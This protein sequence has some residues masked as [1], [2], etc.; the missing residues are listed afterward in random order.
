MPRELVHWLVLEEFCERIPE[1][2]QLLKAN[3]NVMYLGSLVPDAPYYLN[4]GSCP[5]S[6]KLGDHLHGSLGED[7]FIPIKRLLHYREQLSDQKHCEL[8][9]ALSLAILTHIV[10]DAVFHPMLSYLTGNWYAS[11]AS[12]RSAA[13]R[14][15][16][17]LEVY[18]DSWFVVKRTLGNKN[19]VSKLMHFETKN[20]DFFFSLLD[21]CM[22]FNNGQVNLPTGS[23]QKY[24]K[25]LAF[26]QSMFHSNLCG[27]TWRL[28]SLIVPAMR[29]N[30]ACFYFRRRA[31]RQKFS[32]SFTYLHPISGQEFSHSVE[33]LFELSVEQ[34]LSYYKSILD[35]S[36]GTMTGPSLDYGIIG[37]KVS[38]AKHFN[39]IEI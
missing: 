19:L 16:K 4:F 8:A 6:I 24:F 3:S 15:H 11:D 29:E 25:Y 13:R 7:T 9:L 23:W 37:A 12:E 39:P 30:D 27:A 14:R 31:A 38:Q 33:E 36:I 18:L 34:S 20:V 28:L 26:S 35:G 10:T 17:L 32:E 2:S 21:Q 5:N 1:L 22:T